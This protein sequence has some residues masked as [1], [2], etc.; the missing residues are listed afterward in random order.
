LSAI[1]NKKTKGVS[2][3][4]RMVAIPTASVLTSVILFS[5]VYYMWKRKR[6]GASFTIKDAITQHSNVE[7]VR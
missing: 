2:G 3:K 4:Q 1:Y 6:K 5:C 7:I